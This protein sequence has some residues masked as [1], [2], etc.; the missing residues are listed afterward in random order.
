MFCLETLVTLFKRT[1]EYAELAN[2]AADRR[3]TG[4]LGVIEPARALVSAALAEDAGV[5]ILVVAT[6]ERARRLAEELSC[7]RRT[8]VHLFPPPESLPCERI[9]WSVETIRQR[10]QTLLLLVK[11]TTEQLLIVAPVQALLTPLPPPSILRQRLLILAVGQEVSLS[12]LT[13]YLVENQYRAEVVA[14]LPGTF[15]RRGGILD[16]FPAAADQPVR[17]EFFGDMIDSMRYYDPETQRCLGACERVLLSPASEAAIGVEASVLAALRKVT[18][19]GCHTA[20]RSDFERDVEMLSRGLLPAAFG[21]YLSYLYPW[22][23]SLLDY[24]GS[25]GLVLLDDLA[26]ID[27]AAAEY[28]DRVEESRRLGEMG[29]DIPPGLRPALLD[30][31]ELRQR[32]QERGAIELGMGVGEEHTPLRDTFQAQTRF[33]GQIRPALDKVAEKG[34]RGVAIVIS[35]QVARIAELL[36][37][38]GIFVGISN[39]LGELVSGVH[40][41][42]GSYPEGWIMRVPELRQVS[43]FTDTEIF[44]WSKAPSRPVSR[45]AKA[46]LFMNEV[47]PGDYVVHM[48]HGIGRY[49]GLRRLALAAKQISPS[50]AEEKE[51]LEIEYAEGDRLY[52]PTY[53]VD[54]VSR[55][56][57]AGE[58][59]PT[60]TRLGGADWH[61]AKSRA[62][63][64]VEDIADELLDLYTTRSV[65]SGYAYGADD[66]WQWEL[67]AA[68]PYEETEDQLRTIAEV[69]ADMQK[70]RPMD[71]LICGDVGYGKTEVALRAA[72]KA[73]ENG[74]QVAVLVPTTVLAQQHY[75]TFRQR[76]AAFPVTVEM[77]SRFRS[78]REQEAV[79]EKLER[80][81][82]DIVIGTHRLIQ[83]DVRFKDLGLIVV[84]EEQRF[85]VRHKEA[86]KRLRKEVDVLTMTA[87]P[88]PRTLNMALT[89]LRDLSTIDTPPEDRLA[90]WTYVSQWDDNLVQRA[91]NRELARDGQVFL[92]H[93]RVRGIENIA[94]RVRRLVPEARVAVAHGQL[95]ERQLAT[96]MAQFTH[97]QTDVLVCTTIIES[98]LDIPNAN[99]IIINHADHFGLAQL[100]QLRGRVGRGTV[101]AYAYL[102]FSPGEGLNET[103]RQRLRAIME[104][105]DLG[106][107]LQIAMRDLEIRGAGDILGRRQ[108]GHISAVGF[109]LYTRL[110]A[111]AVAERRRALGETSVFENEGLSAFLRPL[112]PSLQLHLPLK[113]ELPD[114]YV[115]D[116]G[117]RLT[118]YRRLASLTSLDEISEFE[119]ELRDRFGTIPAE[120]QSL[121][122]QTRI[123][124]LAQNL[125]ATAIGQEGQ[126]FYV[127]MDVSWLRAGDLRQWLRG[128]GRL[129]RNQVWL[130]MAGREDWQ[131]MLLWALRLLAELKE[132]QKEAIRVE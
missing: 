30:W 52:V 60:L 92:V 130:D 124:V 7:W 57:G 74:K 131:Q 32:L 58:A 37:E 16:V 121:M 3:L 114:T 45:R 54:R 38:H 83:P 87:T 15:S 125:G 126:Q 18:C 25:S 26:L 61:E 2:R 9:P 122:Y 70:P 81:E 41:L 120:A 96:T 27:D 23:Q 110:L 17:L 11:D 20:A 91:I 39:E 88:I 44:G 59:K 50:D 108:H 19:D 28:C 63:R 66:A 56:V 123:K 6:L 129:G 49:L 105:T 47:E 12:Q 85:G 67:E 48:E 43:L 4:P 13:H 103:A 94:S 101:R 79:L 53:Q 31:G 65:V 40:I 119:G 42:E 34:K 76:L 64:A 90:V 78:E 8:G 106:S 72:F 5:T 82:I 117:L 55:Y 116:S 132:E 86:L 107:G 36:Q 68:F 62:R 95:P 127:R 112:Q 111:Q 89:G 33:A 73:V 93:D 115:G 46:D 71:R 29:G 109:D 104:A 102:L 10:L 97:G 51:Y 1:S 69:K 118:L 113:A 99:T 128:L 14:G 80:G 24:I 75:D 100:Y 22:P 84:D 21:M 35:R 98:G 77:L